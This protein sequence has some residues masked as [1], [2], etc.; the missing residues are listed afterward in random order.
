MS[1]PLPPLSFGAVP[2]GMPRPSPRPHWE[3][4]KCAMLL[5]SR[6]TR[7]DCPCTHHLPKPTT[8][9]ICPHA[10]SRLK[11]QPHARHHRPHEHPAQE[12]QKE[13]A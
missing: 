12:G 2:E 1:G 9:P 8:P 4:E 10:P 13:W 7:A 5:F 6:F 11:P 3:R